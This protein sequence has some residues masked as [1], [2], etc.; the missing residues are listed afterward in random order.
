MS[1]ETRRG[2]SA[3]A[4]MSLNSFSSSLH[5]HQLCDG[6]GEHHQLLVFVEEKV[7]AGEVAVLLVWKLLFSQVLG[8]DR[9]HL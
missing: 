7:K 9:L 6:R 2:F 3:A 4:V 8:H 5:S 1:A